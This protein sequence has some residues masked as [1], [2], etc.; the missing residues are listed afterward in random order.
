VERC[1]RAARAAPRSHCQALA[2]RTGGEVNAAQRAFGMDTKQAVVGAV[3]VELVGLEPSLEVQ[4]GE[5]GK[6]GVAF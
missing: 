4:G 6:R 3:S 2:Q 5:D 1:K